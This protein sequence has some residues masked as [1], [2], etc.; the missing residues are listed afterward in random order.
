MSRIEEA[1]HELH[2]IEGAQPGVARTPATVVTQKAFAVVGDVTNGS[3]AHLATLQSGDQIVSFG[4][5]N[6]NNF[7]DLKQL[8][9]IV[10]NSVQTAITVRV[11]RDGHAL[12][13]S[14]SPQSLQA[15]A[16]KLGCRIVP[17]K[18]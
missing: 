10:H 6:A 13:L 12:D 2:A 8:V 18:Q 9:D 11:L 4:S 1:L 15:A 3:P 16:G 7:N 5:L 14:I 17:V